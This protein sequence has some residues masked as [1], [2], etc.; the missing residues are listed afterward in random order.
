MTESQTD[1]TTE[2]ADAWDEL[3][4][5]DGVTDK[6]N[7][8]EL[9]LQPTIGFSTES[10]LEV[11][12]RRESSDSETFEASIDGTDE[13]AVYIEDMALNVE[14]TDHNEIV[15][16]IAEAINGT[17]AARGVDLWA[18]ETHDDMTAAKWAELTGRDRSTVSRN[19]RRAR[20]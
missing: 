13:R 19:I 4:E 3:A 6:Y 20:S 17:S 12:I 7:R 16:E 14:K 18:V 1:D 10:G 8:D 2:E 15:D 5:L 9:E 11:T